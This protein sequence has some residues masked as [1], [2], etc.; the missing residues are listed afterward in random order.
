MARS[1]AAIVAGFLLAVVLAF[2]LQFGM[3][4]LFHREP[5]NDSDREPTLL[6][7]L[8]LTTNA[9]VAVGGYFAGWIAVRRP[10]AHAIVLGGLCL[11]GMVGLTITYWVNEPFWYHVWTLAF[12][13]PAAGIGG[14]LY[15]RQQAVA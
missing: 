10:L 6:V 15:G 12:I 8:L 4:V 14:W 3:M 2:G 9:S 7:I 11:L 13:L 5:V 1:I